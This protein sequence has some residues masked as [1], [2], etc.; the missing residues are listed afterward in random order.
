M[1]W[2]VNRGRRAKVARSRA[3]DRK[4]PS[5]ICAGFENP[6]SARFPSATRRRRGTKRSSSFAKTSEREGKAATS[7]IAPRAIRYSTNPA[8]AEDQFAG[9]KYRAL[10]WRH[11]AL[12]LIEMHLDARGIV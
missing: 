2:G 4:T 11:C 1:F 6:T 8:T 7:A 10:A 12:G 9:V 3:M 5:A